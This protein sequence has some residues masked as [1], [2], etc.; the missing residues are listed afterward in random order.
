MTD[1]AS[2]DAW[3]H[4]LESEESRD[5]RVLQHFFEAHPHYLPGARTLDTNSS[6]HP[7]PHAVIS[8]PALPDLST[9]FPDFMWIASDSAFLYP[10]LIEIETP[11]KRWFQVKKL[12]QHSDLTTAL[13]QVAHWRRWFNDRNRV[14]FYN[15]YRVP[16]RLQDLTLRPRFVVVHGRRREANASPAMTGLRGSLALS[17]DTRLVTFDHLHADPTAAGYFT[18]LVNEHGYKIHPRS[19]SSQDSNCLMMYV[20]R[21]RAYS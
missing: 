17:D 11:W 10:V 12:T 19:P 4:L 1:I 20:M 21:S 7:W 5:E 13:S 3:F 9:K 2:A 6:H 14:S 16:R 8:Q 18:V 15:Y